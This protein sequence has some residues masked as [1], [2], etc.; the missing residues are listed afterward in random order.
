MDN[1]NNPNNNQLQIDLSK[2]LAMGVYS[3][4]AIITHS[5]AEF[6]IDF[7]QMAPGIDKATVRSRVIMAPEHAKRLLHALQENIV[8]YEQ[9]FGRI[10]MPNENRTINPFTINS[11][12]EA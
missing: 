12:G 9:S 10:T 11:G 4:L 8:R 2:E 5:S 6:I 1:K 7:A 3:N